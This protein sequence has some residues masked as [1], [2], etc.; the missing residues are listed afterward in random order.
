MEEINCRSCIIKSTAAGILGEKELEIMED[1]SAKVSFKKGEIIFR[2]GSF[3]SNIIYLRTGL[4]KLHMAGPQKEQ[5]IKIVKAPAYLGIPTTFGDKINNYSATA[6]EETNACFIDIKTFKQLI[7]QN[8]EFAYELIINMCKNELTNFHNWVNL[9]QKHLNGRMA[10]T[11]LFF[12]R[13]IYRK[14]EFEL[15]LRRSELADL[16]CTSRETVSRILTDFYKEKILSVKGRGI[17]ILKKKLLE[18]I[19]KMG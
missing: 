2:Q 4:V 11:V 15:P 13:D 12:S 14:D 18:Q 10:D 9:S 5:I 17:K 8:G 1:N 16:I 3:S 7:Y 6:L 19:S